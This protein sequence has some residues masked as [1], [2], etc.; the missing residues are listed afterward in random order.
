M[1]FRVG[2]KESFANRFREGS[3]LGGML[4]S[5]EGWFLDIVPGQRIVQTSGMSIGENRISTSMVTFELAPDGAGTALTLTHQ[6]AFFEGADGPG[7][8]EAGWR[9]LLENLA[10]VL[11]G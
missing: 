9:K 6:A 2:G 5:S 1:E 8:R 3:V 7:M 11:A 10:A 4:C